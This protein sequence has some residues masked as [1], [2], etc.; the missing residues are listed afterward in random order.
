M[1]H[2]SRCLQIDGEEYIVQSLVL[3]YKL[4]R[5]RYVRDHNK[6]EVLR[7]GRYL[8]NQYLSSMLAASGKEGR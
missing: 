3:R 7:A 1:I 8:V 4:Q 5:G 2:E 6:L